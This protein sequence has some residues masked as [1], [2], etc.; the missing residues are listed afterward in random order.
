MDRLQ[1]TT[2][3]DYYV[4]LTITS[5]STTELATRMTA[6]VDRLQMIHEY[7]PLR[8]VPLKILE[9][10]PAADRMRDP[11]RAATNNQFAAVAAWLDEIER[12]FPGVSTPIEDVPR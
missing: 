9:W 7:L 8:C 3:I 2:E 5:P 10:G 11:Q 1:S 4:Y 6:F 12:R